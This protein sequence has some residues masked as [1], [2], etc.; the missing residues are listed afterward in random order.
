MRI[1]SFWPMKTPLVLTGIGVFLAGAAQRPALGAS[2]PRHACY[3]AVGSRSE[4][5]PRRSSWSP[6]RA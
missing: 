6:Q 2:V 4:E 5:N 1:A 3:E